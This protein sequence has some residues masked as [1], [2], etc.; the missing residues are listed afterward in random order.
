MSSYQQALQDIHAELR[1]SGKS[2][3]AFNKSL[4][5]IMKSLVKATLKEQKSL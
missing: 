5:P 1:A 2:F 4:N 3:I